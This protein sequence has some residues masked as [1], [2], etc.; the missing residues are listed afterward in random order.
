MKED[1]LGQIRRVQRRSELLAQLLRL[2]RR[3]PPPRLQLQVLHQNRP[4][5]QRQHSDVAVIGLSKIPSAVPDTITRVPF[6]I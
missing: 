3:P 6:S 2:P 4:L 1:L 5:P